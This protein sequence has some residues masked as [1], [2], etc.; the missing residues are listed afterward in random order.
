MEL[1]AYG[2]TDKGITRTNNEDSF[3]SE[4]EIGLFIV[5]DGMGGYAAGEVA[6]RMAVDVIRDHIKKSFIKDEPFI[7]GRNDDYA[8]PTNRLASGIRLANQVIYE[9]ARNNPSW[10][11]MGTTVAAVLLAGNTLSIAHVGD[12]RVYLVRA[13]SIEQ[14]TDDHSL[15]SE[16][17]RQGLLTKEEAEKSNVR[18]VITRALGK[19]Q[20]VE[21]DLNETAV[22]EGDRIILCS[23][24]LTSMVP[25]DVIL[26]TV[27]S[28]H[29]PDKA[30]GTLIDI[31]NKNG[32]KDNITTVLVYLTQSNWLS[33]VKKL[34][35]A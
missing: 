21:V 3:H 10:S 8:K 14:L 12:S 33:N 13:D 16:Q 35:R 6:G 32:G 15:V 9:A 18:N 29:E 23:D 1:L 22:M 2:R 19:E 5:A 25:D 4:A 26:S 24:G 7:G 34:F 31:A 11:G 17:V 28:V 27:A 30:C 20:S